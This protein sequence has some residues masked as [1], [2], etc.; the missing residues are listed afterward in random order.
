MYNYAEQRKGDR[1]KEKGEVKEW[2]KKQ[3]WG[4]K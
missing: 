4:K 2:K 1:K 3:E